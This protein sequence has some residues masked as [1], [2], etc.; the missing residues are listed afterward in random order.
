VKG[1]QALLC[2]SWALEDLKVQPLDKGAPHPPLTE[3]LAA[4][5]SIH[6]HNEGE[7]MKRSRSWVAAMAVGGG[8]LLPHGPASAEETACQGTI[9]ATT[10]DNLRVPD[11][12]TCELN[13]TFVKG[14]VKV[15]GGATLKAFGIR[16]IG[17]VQAENARKV[18][19][20]DRSRVG[21]SVQIV[22]GGAAR[23]LKTRITG[24]ILF[25][26]QDTALAAKR[27]RIGGNLQAFQNTGGV[28]INNN[29]IDGNLQCKE[30]VPSPTG[31]GNVVQGNKE[32]QCA[33]L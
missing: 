28:K 16:V 18:V 3:V 29:R 19:V 2:G 12:A 23:I 26:D 8:L 4:A 11:G 13:G 24:D 20:R 1:A 5:D 15:E 21:G 10:V 7:N 6:G 31:G 17:N 25:D 32:D 9:G 22:Q 33:A 27:N 14:T 30:N